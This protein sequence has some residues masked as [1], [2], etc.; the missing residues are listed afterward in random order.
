M[1]TKIT[2]YTDADGDLLCYDCNR[3]LRRATASECRESRD[4]GPTGAIAVAISERT[5][6][7]VHAR[8]RIRCARYEYEHQEG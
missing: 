8:S 3:P 4:A 5:D 2:A 7:R 6:R 1:A